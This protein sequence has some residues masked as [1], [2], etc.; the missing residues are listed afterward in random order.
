VVV[1]ALSDCH[2]STRSLP[3]YGL[4]AISL[5]GLLSLFHILR[6]VGRPD[7]GQALFLAPSRPS[8]RR[9]RPLAW[10][11]LARPVLK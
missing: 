8:L 10:M 4:L 1:A 2:R 7:L 9:Q 6:V 5:T 11:L 3:S